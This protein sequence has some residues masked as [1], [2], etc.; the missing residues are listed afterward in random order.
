MTMRFVISS[1][2]CLL[3]FLCAAATAQAEVAMQIYRVPHG[4]GPHDV[5]PGTGGVVWYTA[6]AQGALGR[7]DPASG[8]VKQIPLGAGSAPHGLVIGPDQAVWITAA[9]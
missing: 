3:C 7:L 9:D 5:A 4:A 1:G 2:I 6:Q 8:A